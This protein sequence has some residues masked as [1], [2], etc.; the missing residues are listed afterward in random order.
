MFSLDNR[1][2]IESSLGLNRDNIQTPDD[3]ASQN[4]DAAIA[5]AEASVTNNKVVN[6]FDISINVDATL[7]GIEIEAQ[8]QAAAQA[9]STALTGA[10]DQ[11]QVNWPTK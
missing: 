7:A 2:P 4:R 1:D 5:Q 11:A 3:I 10:F 9:F 6:N 8:A